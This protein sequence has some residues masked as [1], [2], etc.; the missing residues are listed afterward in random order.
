MDDLT[1]LA[2]DRYLHERLPVEVERHVGSREPLSIIFLD[3]D[4]FKSINDTY[5]HMAGSNTL[6]EYGRLLA[7]TVQDPRATLARYGGDEFV[8]VLPSSSSEQAAV[9][10][11]KIRRATEA[12][13]FLSTTWANGE[14]PLNLGDI[15]TAS[16]GI[17]TLHPPPEVAPD[18]RLNVGIRL[19]QTADKAM[20]DSKDRGKNQASTRT[21]MI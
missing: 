18:Q 13:V 21:F 15:I 19:L 1:G 5:G 7:E 14:T 4:G 12:H 16:I 3:L 17:A 11:E 20:Y 9:V 2:N 8:V 10:A 6:A